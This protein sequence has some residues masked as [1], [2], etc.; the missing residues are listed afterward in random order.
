MPFVHPPKPRMDDRQ[1]IEIVSK[2]P[3]VEWTEI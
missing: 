3:G 1:M 2:I